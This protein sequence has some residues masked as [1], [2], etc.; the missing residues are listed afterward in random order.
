MAA[1]SG[2]HDQDMAGEAQYLTNEEFLRR[3]DKTRFQE[4]GEFLST[5]YSTG[6]TANSAPPVITRDHLQGDMCDMQ[7]IEWTSCRTTRA[8]VRAR[9]TAIESGKLCED[10]AQVRAV[11][12]SST[13]I[14]AVPLTSIGFGAN[15]KQRQLLLIQADAHCP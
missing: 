14:E 11:I 9:R 15:Y 10:V 1:S 13:H 12:S 5:H 3:F 7:G 6:L 4:I 8:Q 2:L